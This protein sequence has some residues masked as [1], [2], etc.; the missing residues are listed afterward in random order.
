MKLKPTPPQDAAKRY[1]RDRR[2]EITDKTH[3]N[4]STT[5]NQFTDWCHQNEIHNM[6]D[7]DSELIDRFKEWRL[8]SVKPITAKNDMSTIKNFIEYAATIQAIHRGTA[9]LIR[10]PR[11]SEDDEIC[12]DFLSKQEATAILDYLNKYEYATNRHLTILLFWK[13][14]MRLSGLWGLD[15]KDFDTTRPALELRHRPTTGTPLKRKSKSERDVILAPETATILTDYL[16]N[17]TTVTDQHGRKPLLTTRTGRPAQTTLQKYV[18]TASRPCEYN[19]GTCPFGREIETCEATNFDT[20]NKCPGSISPHAIRR[21]YVT[22]AQNAGQPKDVTSDRV[23]MS[24]PILDK[25]YDKGTHDEKAE[26]RREH[27]KDF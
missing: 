26:R 7:L 20:A 22:A 5:L 25:H 2:G 14:G 23:N 18:Y 17:K 24:G 1:L 11:V 12:D 16:E 13:A 8:Q 10:I 4:Y 6:N 27:L 21:G 3:Y 9:E 19:G 15:E